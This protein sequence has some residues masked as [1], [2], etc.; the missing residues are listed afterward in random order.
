MKVGL[1]K[2][3]VGVGVRETVKLVPVS[4]SRV[5]VVENVIVGVWVGYD[6]VRLVAEGTRVIV[7]DS[8]VVDVGN[9]VS[10]NVLVKDAVPVGVIVKDGQEVT[11]AVLVEVPVLACV[12]ER[13]GEPD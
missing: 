5:F 1:P 4:V 8:E 10:E 2:V 7:R 12:S 13:V 11:V 9:V 3:R 6:T